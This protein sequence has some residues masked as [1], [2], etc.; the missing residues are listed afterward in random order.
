[1][2]RMLMKMRKLARQARRFTETT[3]H[4]FSAMRLTWRPKC[5]RAFTL[6]ELLVVIAI[7]GILAAL[8][9]PVLGSARARAR[10]TTC[11]NNL[12]QIN[13]G[14]HLYAEDHN[15]TLPA[16]RSLL[17]P[18]TDQ[19]RPMRSYVGLKDAPSPQ[20]RLFACPADT[21]YYNYHDRVSQSLHLQ[22]L[23]SFSS[24]AFNA[25]NIVPGDP[26]VHPWPGVAGWKLGSIKDPVKTILV[27]EFPALLPYS[28]HQPG[29]ESHYNNARD[30]VSF[31]DGHINYIRMYWSTNNF[32]TG[33]EE[34]W[35]YDPPEGYDY[36][37]SGN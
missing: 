32:R 27:E 19:L 22:S 23:Y 34:A 11:L 37:W 6:I 25:G 16:V 26:P 8:L 3:A 28:W 33:N 12:K 35:H 24:Y 29:G 18:F 31:V 10:R 20:D 4:R 13:L 9:L 21:F 2:S 5:R 30:M 1:M 14:V 17:A 15:N 36:K 7:I